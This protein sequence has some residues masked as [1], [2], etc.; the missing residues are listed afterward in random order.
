MRN[1]EKMIEGLLLNGVTHITVRILLQKNIENIS[2]NIVTTFDIKAL[3]AG[4]YFVNVAT[5]TQRY[6]TKIVKE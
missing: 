5:D 3:S 4:M 2:G 1:Y 6:V